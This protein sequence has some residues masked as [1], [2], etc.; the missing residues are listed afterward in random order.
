[1]QEK[2]AKAESII[3]TATA[4]ASPSLSTYIGG[5]SG[6]GTI[7]KT[8]L[9]GRVTVLYNFIGGNDGATP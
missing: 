2:L 5:T 8:T 9:A 3:L 4:M 7:F 6:N 1:M